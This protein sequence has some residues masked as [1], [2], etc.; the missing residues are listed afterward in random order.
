MKENMW[1]L[2][3][4]APNCGEL[5][6][7]YYNAGAMLAD[8]RN[9]MTEEDSKMQVI[10]NVVECDF[11]AY[12]DALKN[13]G[14]KGDLEHKLGFD[15]FFAF[16]YEGNYYHVSYIAKRGEI[17]VVE[18]KS[19]TSINE[20][21]Y[22][23]IG[24]EKT[25]IYQYAL[26]YDPEN[27]VTDKTVNCGMLYIVK[28]SDNSLFMIDG[29]HI[30]QWNEEAIEGLWQFLLKI[31]NTKEDG[32]IRISG[33][34][35]THAH[36]DHLNGCT[37]LLN[38]H[39]KQII[40]ERVMYNFPCYKLCP[41]Y[42]LSTFDMKEIVLRLY[43]QVKVLKLHTGQKFNLSDMTVEVFYTHEDAA[44]K[45]D[46]SK[47]HLGDSNCTSTIIK[48]TIDGKTVMMLGDINV[49]AEEL[50]AKYSKKEIWKSDMVQVAHHC[51]NYLDTLYEWIAAPVAMLPNS[52]FSAHIEN[53][54]LPKLNSI[55]KYVKDNQIYYEG[56]GTDAFVVTEDG[57][58]QVERT[59]LI[60]GEYD[61][62]G[63]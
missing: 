29:G 15:K 60:G 63:Y 44:R 62:S 58:K 39:Y 3:C 17:R 12:V 38:R 5:A 6:N 32:T 30:R 9:G 10:S 41:G 46:L 4:L 2:G 45:E 52:Y 18:D 56:E 23:E 61:Y 35:F 31:T 59:P 26:Y 54:N 20:F 36:D 24:K 22:N 8:D 43:P 28:L 57:W 53:D 34:Y 11:D 21:G 48:L 51:F 49:E 1:V 40:L 14:I 42:V 7:G 55:L 16:T 33:W 19:S 37:K 50:I 47:I 27:H 13:K 25:T